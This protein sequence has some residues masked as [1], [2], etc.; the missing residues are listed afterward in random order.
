MGLHTLFHQVRSDLA[1]AAAA[2]QLDSARVASALGDL[3]HTGRS[4]AAR[5]PASDALL[6]LAWLLFVRAPSLDGRYV[7]LGPVQVAEVAAGRRT[8]VEVIDE[9]AKLEQVAGGDDAELDA[10]LAERGEE[11]VARLAARLGDDAATRHIAA[12][13]ER[14]ERAAVE[15]ARDGRWDE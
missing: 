9:L 7:V 15:A 10:L 13:T 1:D 5:G 4:E 2:G 3:G 8:A 14:A 6:R 12:M 11:L